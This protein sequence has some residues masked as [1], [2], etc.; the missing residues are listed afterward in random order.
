M[1]LFLWKK[2]NILFLK[3]LSHLQ[4]LDLQQWPTCNCLETI[5]SPR[6]KILNIEHW[7]FCNEIIFLYFPRSTTLYQEPTC[8]SES[9]KLKVIQL[10]QEYIYSCV[11]M[12]TGMDWNKSIR[13]FLQNKVNMLHETL[14]WFLTKNLKW[15][16]LRCLDTTFSG[17]YQAFSISFL[18]VFP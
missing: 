17:P 1:R 12:K 10:I 13:K 14:I 11:V 8:I 15:I 4:W 16:T 3:A 6:R 9:W 5:L 18:T 2:E 7:K